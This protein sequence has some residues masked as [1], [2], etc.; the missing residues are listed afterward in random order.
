VMVPARGKF[1]LTTPAQKLLRWM[2][3]FSASSADGEYV[4]KHE[5]ANRFLDSFTDIRTGL[6]LDGTT[7]VLW[8]SYADPL[9][10]ETGDACALPSD[11]LCA[12][13]YASGQDNACR[14]S[15]FQ[16]MRMMDD[17]LR[18]LANPGIVSFEVDD[19][20]SRFI[21]PIQR[22]IRTSADDIGK[23][24]AE[25]NGPELVL[26]DAPETLGNKHGICAVEAANTVHPE[27][28]LRWPLPQAD[29]SWLGVSPVDFEPY[30]TRNRWFRSA[31]DA[32]LILN[33]QQVGRKGWGQRVRGMFHPT[34]EYHA[35]L[36]DAVVCA[37]K[38]ELR[39][40]APFCPGSA[41]AMDTGGR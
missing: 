6:D 14:N 4:I 9:Q 25:R 21:S 41:P 18:F 35:H 8:T 38:P 28:E 22:L 7:Q 37:M 39:G 32:A 19:V 31:N 29:G 12:S 1:W 36:A 34:A 10:R 30:A 40:D 11:D 20:R 15:A 27:N 23:R 3:G 26:V 16:V 13:E 24:W 5:L 33:R 2:F 17:P